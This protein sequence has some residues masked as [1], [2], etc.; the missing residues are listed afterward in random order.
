MIVIYDCEHKWY[1]Y[2]WFRLWNRWMDAVYYGFTIWP[3]ILF[4][5]KEDEVSPWRFKHEECHY[6][7]Q[8]RG[9]LIWY[10]IRYYTELLWNHYHKKMTWFDSYWNISYEKEARDAENR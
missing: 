4:R 5:D 9:L 3:V 1:I 2:W 7:Q 6:Y 8:I 10:I